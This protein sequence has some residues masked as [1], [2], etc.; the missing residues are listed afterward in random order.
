MC[1]AYVR[2][3]SLAGVLIS[4]HEYPQRVSYALLSKV[5]HRIDKEIQYCIDTTAFSLMES[6]K[7]KHHMF[8]LVFAVFSKLNLNFENYLLLAFENPCLI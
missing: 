7:L 4:D 8:Q 1:H 2:N 5:S 6:K 3:D